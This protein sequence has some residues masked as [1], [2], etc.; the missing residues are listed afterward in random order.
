MEKSTE[1]NGKVHS[2]AV[3]LLEL[4]EAEMIKVDP[5]MAAKIKIVPK[6]LRL[7][8][9]LLAALEISGQNQPVYQPVSD[10]GGLA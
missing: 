9:L 10:W 1:T 7:K 5:S 6:E 4:M 2:V 8:L 3:R